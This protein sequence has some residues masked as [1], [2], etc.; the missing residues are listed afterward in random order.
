MV[1]I[2][3]KC[4]LS[5]LVYNLFID[6]QRNISIHPNISI[7]RYLGCLYGIE[8]QVLKNLIGR[9]KIGKTLKESN[10]STVSHGELQKWQLLI[11]G[12]CSECQNKLRLVFVDRKPL[13]TGVL[14]HRFDC[15]VYVLSDSRLQL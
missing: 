1:K 9:K 2:L 13:L 4:I 8:N 12:L 5:I 10:L 3:N 6:R 14:M 7:H 11:G 15:I